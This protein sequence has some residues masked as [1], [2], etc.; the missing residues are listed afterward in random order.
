MLRAWTHFQ[1]CQSN[2]A[3]S[4]L[5]V[6]FTVTLQSADDDFLPS[7]ATLNHL[8]VECLVLSFNWGQIK[9]LTCPKWAADMCDVSLVQTRASV[10][11]LLAQ[12]SHTW[13]SQWDPDD[14]SCLLAS[15]CWKNYVFRSSSSFCRSNTSGPPRRKFLKHAQTISFGLDDELV[16]VGSLITWSSP[17]TTLLYDL[18]VIITALGLPSGH[19]RL[20]TS[21][22]CN[23]TEDKLHPPH[24]ESVLIF[25]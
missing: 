8:T 4:V 2:R 23:P 11:D 5:R 24:K 7:A 17:L 14:F 18:T 13:F 6:T 1:H 16:L 20:A 25:E 15:N 3:G 12:Q 19:T 22:T 10:K 9:N 21:D